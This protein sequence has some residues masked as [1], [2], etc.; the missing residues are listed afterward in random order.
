ME[1]EWLGELR[2]EDDAIPKD[3]TPGSLE[4]I[5]EILALTNNGKEKAH[6]RT[7]SEVV[8]REEM[9]VERE[10]KATE[11]N[12]QAN[13]NSEINEIAQVDKDNA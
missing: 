1:E 7:I 8:P 13:G 11:D 4:A 6:K 9:E 2:T 3:P 10:K 12:A 5:E